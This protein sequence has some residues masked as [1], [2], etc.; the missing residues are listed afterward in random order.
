M[1]LYNG[2]VGEVEVVARLA[3]GKLILQQSYAIEDAIM[4]LVDKIEAA[5]PG[6]QIG[7]AEI[8][9]KLIKEKIG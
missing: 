8:L 9:K 5:I 7:Y 2:R 4:M 1:D 6:D 3:E